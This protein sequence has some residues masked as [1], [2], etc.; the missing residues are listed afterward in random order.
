[1]PALQYI[2]LIQAT[3]QKQYFYRLV[4]E[5]HNLNFKGRLLN[6]DIYTFPRKEDIHGQDS[7][8]Q[9]KGDSNRGLA[10]S[11]RK[12]PIGLYLAIVYRGFRC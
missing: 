7:Q 8:D 4:E 1:M 2:W 11:L 5:M 12:I 10:F 6:E 3:W 9:Y